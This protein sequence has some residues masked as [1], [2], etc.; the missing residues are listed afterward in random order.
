MVK[1]IGNKYSFQYMLYYIKIMEVVF[2]FWISMKVLRLDIR[3]NSR[4]L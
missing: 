1:D 4:I 2:Y 3:R